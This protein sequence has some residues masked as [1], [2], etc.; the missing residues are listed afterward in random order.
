M[1]GPPNAYDYTELRLGL[2]RAHVPDQ[3]VDEWPEA[4]GQLR[5]AQGA[6]LV[7]RLID[8]G[9]GERNRDRDTPMARKTSR[10]GARQ[11]RPPNPP[12]D[13]VRLPMVLRRSV[14][15]LGDSR[16]IFE[17][18]RVAV[19]LLRRDDHEAV[20][21]TQLLAQPDGTGWG[22]VGLA[23]AVSHDR[24]VEVH[25]GDQRGADFVAA[26]ELAQ[27]QPGDMSTPPARPDGT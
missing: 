6:R 27:E 15:T 3:L 14:A 13:T 20:G 24:E 7:E 16:H 9:D 25:Q 26:L 8:P 11:L 22:S 18:T 2:A 4:G 10:H 1:K 17:G 21:A 5:I 12:D 19:L 23:E